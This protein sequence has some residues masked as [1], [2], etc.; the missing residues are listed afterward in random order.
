MTPENKIKREI[1]LSLLK[2]GDIKE[3]DI[4]DEKVIEE[5]YNSQK[6][7]NDNLYEERNE[8]RHGQFETEVEC[9]WSRHYESKSVGA[10]MC[11][12]TYVGWT[13]WYG[14]GKHGEPEAIDWM[15]RAYEIKVKSREMVEVLHFEKV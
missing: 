13:Y 3:F 9:N 5:L 7:E 6:N 14:G 15:D 10:K 8:F 11:D 2:N 1:L 4:N 12:G